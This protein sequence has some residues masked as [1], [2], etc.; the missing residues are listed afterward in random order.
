MGNNTNVSYKAW[1]YGIQEF[2]KANPKYKADMVSMTYGDVNTKLPTVVAAG[3][4]PNVAEQ[5]RYT[6]AGG[7]ARGLMQDISA[8]AKTAGITGNDQQP[9]CWREVALQGKLYGLPFTT[10]SRMV[11]VNV[12]QLNRAGIATTAPKT[13]DDYTQIAQKL[14]TKQGNDFQQL[15]YAPWQNNW[16]MYGW[17]WL[18]GG[19]FYNAD[20]N[21]ATLDDAKNIAALDWLGT[22]AKQLGYAAVQ[23]FFNKQNRGDLFSRK[24]TFSTSWEASDFTPVAMLQGNVP[25]EPSLDWAV[26][27]PPPPPGVGKT[28]TWSGGFAVVLPTAAKQTDMAFTLM[29]YLSDDKFQLYQSKTG[30]VLPTIK[31]VAADA[32]WKTVDPRIKQCVDMLPFSHGRPAMPQINIMTTQLGTAQT[33]VLTGK[34]SPSQALQDANQQVNL[35]IQ[36]NRY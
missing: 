27:A 28:S 35:A 9:W 32:Y 18:F 23:A 20:K 5:D 3:T 31:S 6:I 11:F 21:Q 2:E 10:D 25:P 29:R 24:Q 8:Y 26:W 16:G 4:P 12:N 19:D 15:G 34:K 33:D 7:A 30:L 1:V 17:G 14:T 13:L 36:Q 22:Q